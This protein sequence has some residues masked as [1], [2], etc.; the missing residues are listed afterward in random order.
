MYKDWLKDYFSFTKKERNAVLILIFLILIIAVVPYLLPHK[1]DY[2]DK[3]ALE[4]FQQEIARLKPV[5][6]DSFNAG[7]YNSRSSRYERYVP[8]NVK[9]VPRELFYFD[10][11]TLTEENWKKLGLAEKTARTIRHYLEKGGKF[12]TPEDIGKIYSLKKDEVERLLPYIRLPTPV[13]EAGRIVQKESYSGQPYTRS[14]KPLYADLMID[15]N[16]TDTTTLQ[17]LPGIGSK[18]AARIIN[19]KEKLGG[20]YAVDQVAETYG[21]PDSTFQLIKSHLKVSDQQVTTININGSDANQLKQHPYFRW[22]IANAIV[23]Y[24]MQHG[25]FK[26]KEDL[27]QI[28]A[29][30]PEL[31]IKLIPY[32]SVE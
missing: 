15:I 4:Q 19:F 20:F 24:R 17:M 22:N 16:H 27:L 14:F 5:L 32:I 7:G 23:Q 2:L 21:L 26:N 1:R 6:K 9:T 13:K 12:R 28:A 18:L 25:N 30:S 11:N 29:I 3:A 10:P 31:Y 8:S